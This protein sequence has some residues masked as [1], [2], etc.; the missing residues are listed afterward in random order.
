MPVFPYVMGAAVFL[1]TFY[2]RRLVYKG[3]YASTYTPDLVKRRADLLAGT[4]VLVLLNP[5]LMA[6][7]FDAVPVDETVLACA[8]MMVLVVV[9]SLIISAVLEERRSMIEQRKAG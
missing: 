4:A 3:V 1:A 6:W 5:F 9:I 2:A 8:Y 7:I